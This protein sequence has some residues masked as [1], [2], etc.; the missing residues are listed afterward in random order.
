MIQTKP[1]EMGK[2]GG[3][4]KDMLALRRKA[5]QEARENRQKE[6]SKHLSPKRSTSVSISQSPAPIG[7]AESTFPSH[8]LEF[9][10]ESDQHMS[11]ADTV[12]DHFSSK[13]S[14]A[15]TR[16]TKISS[17]TTGS[18]EGRPRP[19]P[20]PAALPEESVSALKQKVA[21]KKKVLQSLRDKELAL[22]EKYRGEKAH[23]KSQLAQV[24]AQLRSL[25]TK[26]EDEKRLAE[27]KVRETNDEYESNLLSMRRKV[28]SDVKKEYEPQI[29]ALQEQLN[30]LRAEE[31]RLKDLLKLENGTKDLV[32]S[33]VAAATNAIIHKLDHVFEQNAEDTLAWNREIEKLVGNEVRSSFAVSVGS[34]AQSEREEVK[35][36]FSDMLDLW[37]KVEDEERDRILKMDEALLVDIQKMAQEDLVRLQ[38]EEL[39]MEEVYVRSREA[40]A[41]Q[42]QRL[43]DMEQEAA[44]KRREME[45]AEQRAQRDQLHAER[46]RAIE[47]MHQQQMKME[48]RQHE[49][50]MSV[51]KEHFEREEQLA[52]EQHRA[53]LSTQ[54]SIK[55]ATESFEAS[56]RAV[57]D[58][59]TVLK[60]YQASVDESQLA[61]SEERLKI[62]EDR[63]RSLESIKDL[64][65]SQRI[66]VESQH[67]RL[68]STIAQI[69]SLG[70]LITDHLHEEE[71]WLTQQEA[72]YS[73]SREEWEREYRRWKQLV[74]EERVATQE[75]FSGAL[76]AL[77]DCLAALDAEEK[78]VNIE[79]NE[80]KSAFT[81][82]AME[83]EKEVET[84]ESRHAELEVRHE[85]VKEVLRLV[86][87]K[88]EEMLQQYRALQEQRQRLADEKQRLMQETTRIR[89]MGVALQVL[90]SEALALRDSKALAE[91]QCRLLK[92]DDS[93][94]RP[95][96][97]KETK[98][99][100]KGGATRKKENHGTRTRSVQRLPNKLLSELQQQ[101]VESFP[102]PAPVLQPHSTHPSTE[103]SASDI[104]HSTRA[105]HA[106]K[107]VD[108]E[109]GRDHN[110]DPEPHYRIIH[111]DI[112]H[113]P[114]QLS[115]DPNS[116]TTNTFTN[117]I[118]ISDNSHNSA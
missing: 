105:Q 72:R 12:I 117:L 49:K 94:D 114:T 89:D 73:A 14:T 42:H 60:Q 86:E 59:V 39:T 57:D 80:M 70:S 103:T 28:E 115:S 38:A 13:A 17:D 99:L 87:R 7:P 3:D 64:I 81:D 22:L 40:W 83:T 111:H 19:A 43:L 27:T 118:T 112:Q 100:S 45:F 88:S 69:S 29:N 65:S 63:E 1:P 15:P 35:K 24:E 54:Q 11:G 78:E 101:L 71:N 50:E 26:L 107:Y 5:L 77:Q 31:Q 56:L 95:I 85:S 10:E 51:L 21:A 82:I 104:Q 74:E 33:A 76:S 20:T 41:Q 25:W 109:I 97:K 116:S 90:K 47:E 67:Q 37:R 53:V 4:E 16:Q 96:T 55:H 32:E 23:K 108:P 92:N 48:E 110:R 98:Q 30:D 91:Q 61:V 68:S 36:H 102:L 84:L 8:L 62:V 46:L 6:N 106:G 93:S 66:N 75:Q 18:E 113:S 2:S 79:M 52:E 34:E 9:S 44:I 58:V